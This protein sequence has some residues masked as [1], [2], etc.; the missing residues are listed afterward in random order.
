MV[1]LVTIKNIRA[2]LALVD[3]LNSIGIFCEAENNG[4][5]VDIY[6]VDAGE[7]SRADDIVKEFLQNPNQE[8]FLLA[9]WQVENPQHVEFRSGNYLNLREAIL[10]RVGYFT[11]TVS[12]L[13]L[14]VF[15]FLNSLHG[16]ATFDL[17]SFPDS[18]D[19]MLSVQIL[20][21][22][23]GPVFM[24]F[25]IMHIIFNLLWWWVFGGEVEK[26]QGSGYLILIIL[27][28]GLSSNFAQFISTGPEFGGLS[29]VVYGLLGYC[30][31]VG[32]IKPQIGI[33]VP[34]TLMK[35]LMV[36][37]VLC[38][39]D[40]V[41]AFIGPIANTAHTVGLLVGVFLGA[42]VAINSDVQQN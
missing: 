18:V 22:G 13:C 9:S 5:A 39:T 12:V 20:W 17:L 41:T 4:S 33:S 15:G 40:I 34:P 8:K 32:K 25:S 3:Y 30:W 2:A 29:G 16:K 23:L 7:K 10:S 36:W 19:K 24:H 6:L 37:L 38:Y 27:V 26:K 1:F 21:R 42:A 11:I 31:M 14:I 28:T 35:F